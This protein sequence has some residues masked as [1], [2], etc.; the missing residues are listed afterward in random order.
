[1]TETLHPEESITSFLLIRH[2][3]T[4]QTEEGKLYTDPTVELT[5]QGIE[6]AKSL[7]RWLSKQT[8][9][10]VLSSTAKR[11]VSTAELVSSALNMVPVPIEGLDEWSV[12]AWEGRSYLDIKKNNPDLYKAWSS[13]PIRN[14]PPEG[15]SIADLCVRIDKKLDEMIEKYDGQRLALITHSGVIRAILVRALAMPLDNFWRI[16]IPVGSITR[17]D[18][19]PNFA[20]VHYT[21]LRPASADGLDAPS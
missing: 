2:G 17:V 20:T 3:H 10:K 7:G 5:E 14:A 8:P 12:G 4:K 18:F 16:S 15:E 13:D 1:M 19:S 9:D 11:V 21:A 6:Q